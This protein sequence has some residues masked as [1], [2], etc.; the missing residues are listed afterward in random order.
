MVIHVLI[1]CIKKKNRLYKKYLRNPTMDH[2]SVYKMYK[3][4]CCSYLLNIGPNLA[5]GVNSHQLH[6]IVFWMV[7]LHSQYSSTLQPKMRSLK[8]QK[9][10]FQTKQLA[11][12]RFQWQSLRSPFHLFLNY[13]PISQTCQSTMVL[14]P[15][16]WKALAWYLFLNLMM[17]SCFLPTTDLSWYFL[18]FQNSLKE[19][20]TIV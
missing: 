2:Q 9:P 3:N 6:T 17:I 18:A 19:L 8:L 10:F 13:S 12:T 4:N 15:M 11:T 7:P 16:K 20:S 5:P 14:F 1:K